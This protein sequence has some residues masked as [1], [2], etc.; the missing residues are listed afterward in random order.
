MKTNIRVKAPAVVNHEGVPAI[1]GSPIQQLRRTVLAAMLFEDGFYESGQTIADRVK[2][3]VPTCKPHEV[4]ELAI[5]AR[6]KQHLRHVPLLLVRELARNAGRLPDELAVKRLI[7]RVVQRA[8][9]LAEFLAIYWA[10]EKAKDAKARAPLSAQVKKG[11]GAA[12]GKF[13]EY[14]LA[15]YT[16]DDSIK[17]RDVAMLVH[18]KPKDPKLMARLIN[19]TFFPFMTKSG[20]PIASMFG[21]G[22]KPGLVSPDTW[23]VAL[24]AGGDKRESFER[25]LREKK[26]GYMALL[27]NLRNMHQAGVDTSLV[28]DALIAGAAKAKALP[29]RYIAA[30]RAVPA[31]EA[32]IDEAMKIALGGMEKLPGKTVVLVDTSP[33]MAVKISAKSDLNRRDGAAAL[34]ILLRGVC[35]SARVFAFSDATVEVP[36]RQGMA[37]ADAILQATPS[38][39]TKLGKAVQAVARAVPDADRLIVFTDEESQDAVGEPHCANAYMVNVATSHHGVGYGKWTRISGFSEAVVQYIAALEGSAV[40]VAEA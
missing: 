35:E 32:Q 1:M 27:R 19:K 36:P 34:A 13:D 37:L 11:L 38:D 23:E 22:D 26:L 30:A 4:A 21:E 33:S 40:E 9:E 14:Q 28:F 31:W 20:A 7:P 39:G 3:L 5:E 18:V 16:R 2:S 15:K 8:D 17:L 24:S 12:F 6:E 10:D 29:F 25:L